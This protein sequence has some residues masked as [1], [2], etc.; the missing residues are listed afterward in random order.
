MIGP[1]K[2]DAVC[3]SVRELTKAKGVLIM[4]I[5]GDMGDGFSCQMDLEGILRLPSVLRHMADQIEAD[6]KKGQL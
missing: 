2:Y 1:G 5:E 3:T 6:H 4:V